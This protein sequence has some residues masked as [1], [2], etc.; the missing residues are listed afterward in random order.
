MKDD[1][2]FIRPV[3]NVIFKK[4][5]PKNAAISLK[6]SL[7]KS[8]KSQLLMVGQKFNEIEHLGGI[9]KPLKENE[10]TENR[11][12]R[13]MFTVLYEGNRPGY[14][15]SQFQKGELENFDESPYGV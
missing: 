7:D 1:M 12:N 11:I 8:N 10:D 4:I 9:V 5:L 14:L 15:K 2:D 13:R 3:S 6:A